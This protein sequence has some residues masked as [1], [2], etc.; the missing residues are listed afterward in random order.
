[1]ATVDPTTL[2]SVPIDTQFSVT[3]VAV[4]DVD[5]L[6]GLSETITSVT[7]TLVGSP[8]ES[9]IVITPGITSVTIS[10]KHLN[11]FTDVFTYVSRGE[12]DKTETPT[13]VIGRGNVPPVK[14]LY[15]LNQDR[16]QFET[17]TFNIVINGS[18]TIPVTQVVQNPLEL[19][20][21]FMANYNYNG[22]KG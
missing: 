14:N 13:V 5:E 21:L 22:A 8:E 16:R 17:R 11:T 20:R 19:M 3:V 1:M 7:A 12:S 18:Q 6:S 2:P 15:D 10:G 4:P 9:E